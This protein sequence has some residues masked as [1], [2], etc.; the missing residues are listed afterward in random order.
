MAAL[1]FRAINGHVA[2]MHREN[3][4]VDAAFQKTG[5]H[6]TF[7]DESFSGACRGVGVAS[8]AVNED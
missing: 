8:I 6:S 7:P 1:R 2:A 4:L 5:S 3:L